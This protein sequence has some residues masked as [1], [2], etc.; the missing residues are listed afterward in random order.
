M[1]DKARD[2]KTERIEQIVEHL[3][4]RMDKKRAPSVERFVRLYYQRATAADLA[5]NSAENLYG[6]AF[7]L[8]KFAEQRDPG[9]PK[10]RVLNPRVDEQGWKSSH[11]VIEIVT[12]DMPFLVDSIT[13]NLNRKGYTVHLVIHPI[14]RVKRDA[15]GRLLE[16]VSAKSGSEAA[17]VVAESHM[18]V[19]ISAQSS[20]EVLDQIQ[21]SIHKVL[22]DVQHAV[23]GLASHAGEGGRSHRRSQRKPTTGRGGRDRRDNLVS[24]VVGR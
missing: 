17:N 9:V 13:A 12:D 10:V 5:E 22:V 21:E 3:R 6:A 8:W 2:R 4:A 23:E 18:H 15:K 11:T 1:L 7:S 19:E 20:P 24:R 16:V 14:V